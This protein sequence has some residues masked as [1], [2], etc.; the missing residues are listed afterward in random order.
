MALTVNEPADDLG[1]APADIRLLIAQY[2]GDV[3]MWEEST[4]LAPEVCHDVSV[5]LSPY[6]QRHVSARSDYGD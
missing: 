3:P 1:V 2:S 4:V 6:G 5:M